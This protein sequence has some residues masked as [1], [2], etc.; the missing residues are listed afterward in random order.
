[1][2]SPLDTKLSFRLGNIYQTPFTQDIPS[3]SLSKES[4]N[5]IYQSLSKFNKERIRSDKKGDSYTLSELKQ[6]AEI[7]GIRKNQNKDQLVNQILERWNEK[8][9]DI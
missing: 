9:P 6:I 3:E 2:N 5:R 4:D 1:M 8:F 7:L